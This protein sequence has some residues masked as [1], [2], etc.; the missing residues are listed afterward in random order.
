VKDNQDAFGHLLL[1]YLEH[2][3]GVEIV[4]R[5]DGWIRTSA[6]PLA[7]FAEYSAWP[8]HQQQAIQYVIG[9]VLDI[10][11]GAGRHSLYLQ[12]KGF[13]VL[14]VDASPLAIEVCQRRG[15]KQAQVRSITQVSAKLGKFD[16]ILMLGNNF[17]LVGSPRRAK[18]LLKRFQSMTSQQARLI[19]ESNDIYQTTDPDHLAYQEFN[20][21]RNRM[22]GQIRMR[23]RY[24]KYMMPWFDYLMVS[25]DEMKAILAGTGWVVKQFIDSEKTI[26]AA[27]IEK[28]VIHRAE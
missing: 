16:T 20:R 21:Q 17:G 15:L 9:R 7:Y 3:Q 13:D 22:P 4:E 26:Y 2:Q 25:K 5:E 24:K 10:G 28:Q 19:V 27:V 18:W 12:Q 14:G 8:P 23:V 6:G 11:C 1:D